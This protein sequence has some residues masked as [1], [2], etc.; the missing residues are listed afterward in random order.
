MIDNVQY[1]AT[2]NAWVRKSENRI[3]AVGRQAINDAI[4]MA[5]RT[6]AGRSRGGVV[7]E[8]FVPRAIGTLAASLQSTLH[9]STILTHTG[10]NSHV[11]TVGAFKAGDSATFIWT[12]PYAAAL[13]YDHGWMWVDAMAAQWQSIVTNAVIRARARY[14]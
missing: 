7:R 4:I 5:S 3:Q 2:L 1:H 12:A 10:Q 13:H 8:G 9:G 11:L 6:A 14:P